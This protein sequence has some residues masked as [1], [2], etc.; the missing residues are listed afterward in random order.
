MGTEVRNSAYK[1]HRSIRD[2]IQPGKKCLTILEY[3]EYSGLNYEH[4]Y[5]ELRGERPFYRPDENE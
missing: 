1:Y 3:C 2:A 5:Y 4:I